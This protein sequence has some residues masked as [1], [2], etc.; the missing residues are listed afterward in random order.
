MEADQDPLTEEN[1]LLEAIPAIHF[2]DGFSECVTNFNAGVVKCFHSLLGP[3]LKMTHTQTPEKKTHF[4][5]GLQ[6]GHPDRKR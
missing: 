5:T 1:G 6:A 3:A 4:L 2:H